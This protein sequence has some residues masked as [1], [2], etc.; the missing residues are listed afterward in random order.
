MEL[1][2]KKNAEFESS[3]EITA[4]KQTMHM[5]L[6]NDKEVY[7][8]GSF[9]YKVNNEKMERFNQRTIEKQ[10]KSELLE[11][12]IK[13]FVETVEG[14]YTGIYVDKQAKKIIVF[15]DK[16]KRG[17]IFYCEDGNELLIS[18]NLK[19]LR[20]RAKGYNQN[21]LIS[22]IYLYI[23]KKHT[24]FNNIF[25]L[26]YNEF[27]E[28]S[29][30]TFEVKYYEEEPLKIMEYT[31]DDLDRF[32]E[33][34]ENSIISR[35]S[36]DINI[37]QMSGGWDSSFLAA[38]LIK[39][40]DKDKIRGI[41]NIG[42]FSEGKNYNTTEVQKTKKIAEYLNVDLEHVSTHYGG[43]DLETLWENEIKPVVTEYG[44][45][46]GLMV[47]SFNLAKRIK[48]KYG[49]N[50]VVFNGEACDSMN[51]FGFSQFISIAHENKG[52][53]EYADKMMCYLYGPSFFKKVL[54]NTYHND[55]V[56]QIYLW[57]FKNF[58]LIDAQNLS[59]EDRI[60]EYLFSFVYGPNRVP[61]LKHENSKFVSTEKFADF[62]KWVKSEYFDEVINN[63]T[64]ENI[65][66]WLHRLY[67]DFHWQSPSNI[68][69]LTTSLPNMRLPYLDYNLFKFFARMPESWGRGLELNNVKFPLKSIIRSGIENDGFKYP[70]HIV[71]NPGVHSYDC[72][73]AD[74]KLEFILNS[75]LSKY[76][77]K[78]VNLEDKCNAFF[79]DEYFKKSAMIKLINDLK[80]KRLVNVS[81]S[82]YNLLILLMI[83][84]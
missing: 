60:F 78:N 50:V 12:K 53:A 76:F 62:K 18:T 1:L 4:D 20:K 77:V 72:T 36:D 64:P 43:G 26:R 59:K 45:Y 61:F 17:E 55:I 5:K 7:L 65:Y 31:N 23:P 51:N 69:K 10:L 25:R 32:K 52:F 70:L 80:N 24:L 74:M 63:I 54:D 57:Y 73:A 84:E 66:Y 14:T 81:N 42:V 33:L 58:E 30:G 29:D 49:T 13:D 56:Y 79:K 39:H 35:A 68:R 41:F 28:I 82:D 27:I 47:S 16:L 46:D 67:L 2:F 22:A 71:N 75:T 19:N 34:L 44:V 11:T 37:V 9:F 48:E 38:T 8:E 6:N 83:A 3:Y 21:A 15:S 40:F